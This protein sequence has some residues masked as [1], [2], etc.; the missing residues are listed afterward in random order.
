M[1]LK[2]YLDARALRRTRTT[3]TENIVK[4]KIMEKLE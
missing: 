2:P 3:V 4:E 1:E